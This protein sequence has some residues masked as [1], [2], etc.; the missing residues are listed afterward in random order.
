[1]RHKQPATFFEDRSPEREDLLQKK[2]NELGLRLEGTVLEKLVHELEKECQAAGI[3]KL[4]PVC[5]LTE[6]W[7]VPEGIPMIGI[8]Y[9]LADERLKKLEEDVVEGETEEEILSYLRHEMGHAFCYAYRLYTSEEWGKLFG[10]PSRPYIEEYQP[11]PFSRDFVRHIP[12]WYAQKHPD[13]DFAETFAVWLTPGGD[14]R[15]RYAGTGAERKLDYVEKT[16]RRL[17][18][19]PPEVVPSEA[20]LTVERITY[21]VAEHLARFRDPAIDVP[22]YFDGDLRD[23]FG[24]PTGKEGDRERAATFL[25]RH[26]RMIVKR[27]AHWTGVREGVIRSLV[28]HLEERSEAL[29]LHVDHRRADRT[30]IDAMA[31]MTTLCMNY[32]YK[33]AFFPG[34]GATKR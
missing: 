24:K 22:P 28:A 17:G 15:A 19:S 26:R 9:Y 33:G 14:W 5:Y 16:V 10:P 32:L 29:G 30:L 20:D 7:G 31:Y 21:T 13:E 3:K 34:A 6:E 1:M 27:V 12:G 18:D 25:K 8:P 4:R 11:E 23:L 2:V